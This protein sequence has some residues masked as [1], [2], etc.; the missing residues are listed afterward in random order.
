MTDHVASIAGDGIPAT[1]PSPSSEP[2]AF[3]DSG[4][5]RSLAA[6]PLTPRT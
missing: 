2:L 5:G 1:R 6:P 3:P 4:G